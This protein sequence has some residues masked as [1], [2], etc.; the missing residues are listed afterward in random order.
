MELTSDSAV[1]AYHSIMAEVATEEGVIS[2]GDRD[3]W[4]QPSKLSII[5]TGPKDSVVSYVPWEEF[6]AIKVQLEEWANGV[7]LKHQCSYL[8]I[9]TAMGGGQ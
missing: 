7:C 4:I 1:R 8:T 5:I 2:I 3:Y 6:M 9:V